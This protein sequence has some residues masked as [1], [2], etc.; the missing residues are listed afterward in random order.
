MSHDDQSVELTALPAHRLA[1]LLRDREVSAREVVDAHIATIEEVNARLNAVVVPRFSDARE[2]AEVVD[3]G[4]AAGQDLGPLAGLPVTVKECLDIA[5]LPSTVGLES[6][7]NHVAA[8]DEV[9]VGR[10]RSAGAIVLAKTNLAQMLAFFETDNPVYGRSDNPWDQDR[11]PGGSSG[12]EAAIIAANGSPLGLGTD[13]GGSARNP[14]AVCGICG[15]KPSAGRL[16]DISEGSFRTDLAIRSEVGILARHTADIILG[17]RAINGG[18]SLGDPATVDLGAIRVA[19]VMTDG[20][21]D[22]C[23][24]ARRAVT[25][26]ADA[27]HAAGAITEQ[28]VPP[29]PAEGLR[30]ALAVLGFDRLAHLT[31]LAAGTRVDPRLRQM[32][33]IAGMP[34]LL[35]SSSARLLDLVG[36]HG[37]AGATRLLSVGPSPEG[38]SRTLAQ[39][40]DYRNRFAAGLAAG[41]FD[42]VLLPA[43][44]LPALPHG[45]TKNLATLG[46]YTFV[47]NAFGYPA[48]VVPWTSVR[49]DEEVGRRPTRDAVAKT[50]RA[51]ELGSAGL[52]VGVQIPARP[53]ADH[54]ALALM[55]LVEEASVRL[56]EHPGRPSL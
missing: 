8:G 45:A 46:A 24:A 38:V 10:L 15:F 18:M 21:L 14:A 23:P 44:P 40:E 41:A 31:G 27:L 37:L 29:D 2:E 54:V 5:G 13:I 9:Y 48:G 55:G 56:G 25:E 30:L 34:G 26:A 51:A 6:R 3:R 20:I 53:G 32:I 50:A 33:R 17:L 52:P 43:S 7:R 19:V 28:W 22:P 42:A 4:R 11:S 49:A 39:L 35:R 47:W 12:G 1:R 16:P 36:Q